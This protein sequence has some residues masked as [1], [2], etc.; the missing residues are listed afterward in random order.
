[1]SQTFR[2][3]PSIIWGSNRLDAN[4]TASADAEQVA[5]AYESDDVPV[6]III[7]QSNADG[8]GSTTDLPGVDTA[9]HAGR[10]RVWE[11]PVTRA[12]GSAAVNRVENGAWKDYAPGDAMVSPVDGNGFGPE[13]AIAN[14]WRDTHYVATGRPL[15]LI[16]LAIGGTSLAASGGGAD[17]S[18][19][20]ADDQL[21]VLAR[22]FMV[23]PALR[24]LEADGL[25]PHCL[26]FLW[27]QGESDA[28]ASDAAT[29]EANL[30]AF[31]A[32]F[33]AECGAVAAPFFIV[34]LSDYAADANWVAVKTAQAAVAV[35]HPDDTVLIGT[36]G[37][38]GLPVT[39]FA[40]GVGAGAIHLASAGLFTVAEKMFAALDVAAGGVRMTASAW[41]FAMVCH[42]DRAP[43]ASEFGTESTFGDLV[44][45][46]MPTD[47]GTARVWTW[48]RGGAT[49]ARPMINSTPFPTLQL[50]PLDAHTDVEVQWRFLHDGDSQTK[51]GFM[52]RAAESAPGVLDSGYLLQVRTGGDT[53]TVFRIAGGTPTALVGSPITTTPVPVVSQL[54]W[55]RVRMVGT[56]MT[57]AASPDGTAWTDQAVFVDATYAAGNLFVT[58]FNGFLD[59]AIG[60]M[61]TAHCGFNRLAARPLQ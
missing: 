41:P 57:V 21:R 24:A 31:I 30:T 38:D 20:D 26:G 48:V 10:V 37:T 40:D 36:D 1:M 28:N 19:D 25:R 58:L 12:P 9:G 13:L 59:K 55:Y 16:K 5:T 46:R 27:I 47:S 56:T 11:K 15:H 22:D 35:A 32:G 49:P 33:R 4:N 14:M 54:F 29:Y 45:T 8:R 23:L 34:Q 6:L 17:T 7:G 61:R 60:N 3:R 50:V 42:E 51:P 43:V 52:V 18:W 44:P 39:R 2:V 53:L